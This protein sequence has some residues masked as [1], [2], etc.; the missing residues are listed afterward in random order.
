MA[1][2]AAQAVNYLVEALK[3]SPLVLGE[4]KVSGGVYPFQRPLNST[5]EDVVVNS[6]PMGR[7]AV[8]EGVL[9]VNVFVPNKTYHGATLTDTTRPNM[10]RL[11]ALSVKGGEVL[12][13]YWSE[14]GQ[15]SY[16]LL[17]DT[18]MQDENSQHYINFRVIFRTLNIR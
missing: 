2:T 17:Q 1:I 6:L 3:A 11:T 14:D 7:G 13:D 16:E 18:I 12:N 10:D 5:K 4:E 15:I 8:Q 9:N